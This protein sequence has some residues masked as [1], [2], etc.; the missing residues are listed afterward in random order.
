M[1]QVPQSTLLI[2]YLLSY[3]RLKTQLEKFTEGLEQPHNFIQEGNYII[4]LGLAHY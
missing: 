2:L 4:L 3:I 1:R